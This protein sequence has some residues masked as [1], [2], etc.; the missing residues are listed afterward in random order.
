MKRLDGPLEVRILGG[1]QNWTNIG[2]LIAMGLS[3]YFS[4]L[5]A[6]S[7][8]SAVTG[9]PGAMAMQAPQR[10]ADGEFHMGFTT[11][12]WYA[13]MAIEGRGPFAEPLPLS[14]LAVFPH[15]DRLAFAVRRETGLRS[16]HEVREQKYPLR[17]STPSRE[18]N[19]PAGWVVEAVLERYG[20]T[21]DDIE[22]WGGKILHDR[23]RSQN[24]PSAVP[25][26]PSF[27]AVF[28][29]AI[30][31]RRWHKITTQYDMRFLPLDR[32]ILD[33]LVEYGMDAGTIAADRLQGVHVDV[34][35]VDFTG[36]ALICRTDMNEELGYLTAAAIHERHEQISARF[37]DRFDGMT[38]PID[39]HTIARTELPVHA[40]A[41][42]YYREH[43]FLE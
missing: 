40:G 20:I 36:W 35:A 30:M 4:K 14:V 33:G 10:V 3:G 23:P 25:V 38:A 32:D 17:L 11:P 15:D 12:L 9:D 28:D 24:S 8:V 5:P 2:S 29:E 21:L 42:T 31:T 1:G 6:G 43:G 34:P 26:D 22:S 37:S 41:Q 18:M 39:M 19:H 16:L 13:R 7:L 27:D